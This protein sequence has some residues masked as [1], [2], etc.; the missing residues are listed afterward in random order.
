MRAARKIKKIIILALIP[1]ILLGTLLSVIPVQS[2]PV[3]AGGLG[4]NPFKDDFDYTISGGKLSIIDTNNLVIYKS[5][6]NTSQSSSPNYFDCAISNSNCLSSRTTPAQIIVSSSGSCGVGEITVYETSAIRAASAYTPST[7]TIHIYNTSLLT[8]NNNKLTAGLTCSTANTTGPVVSQGSSWIPPTNPNLSQC[9]NNSNSAGCSGSTRASCSQNSNNPTCQTAQCEEAN[10]VLDWAFCAIY[11]GM[12]SISNW[13]LN[14]VIQPLLE[15]T[16][17]C[18]NSQGTGCATSALLR[19]QQQGSTILNPTYAIWSSFRLYGDIVLVIAL[20]VAVISEAA[21]GG[22]LDTYT[23]RKMLPRILVAGILLNLSIYIVAA[24]VDVFNILGGT[25]GSIITAPIKNAGLFTITPTKGAGIASWAGVGVGIIVGGAHLHSLFSHPGG[26]MLIDGVLVPILLILLAIVITIIL[27]TAAITALVIISPIAFALYCLPNTQKYFKRWWDL[28]LEMLLMYPIITLI[29]AV[30]SVMSVIFG[31]QA[32]LEGTGL[33]IVTDLLALAFTFLPLLMI[34]FS[35]KLAGETIGRVAGAVD[36]IRSKAMQMHAPR[37][38]RAKEAYKIR[39]AGEKAKMYSSGIMSDRA[40]GRGL[41]RIP[42]INRAYRGAAARASQNARLMG[43]QVTQLPGW[44]AIEHDDYALAALTNF[45]NE[46]ATAQEISELTG[47]DMSRSTQAAREAI[48]RART[49]VDFGGAQAIMA[50]RQRAVTGTGYANAEQME[51]TIARVARGDETTRASLAGDINSVSKQVGR[52]DLGPGYSQVKEMADLYDKQAKGLGSS[53]HKDGMTVDEAIVSGMTKNAIGGWKSGHLGD[54][55]NDKPADIENAA[56]A[57][58]KIYTNPNSSAEEVD[59][60]IAFFQ[61][62]NSLKSY[63][64]IKGESLDK[65]NEALTSPEGQRA[66]TAYHEM[67]SDAAT[68]SLVGHPESR[69][70]I[71]RINQS[72]RRL[73]ARPQTD[74]TGMP[75][76]GPSGTNGETTPPGGA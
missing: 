26:S 31:F 45:G 70:R 59:S 9:S 30:S 23:V 22:L 68:G 35:F 50:A 40:L 2:A 69:E 24:L 17:I 55:A 7:S 66:L 36:G 43:N 29:F 39:H 58:S 6:G 27:R 52:H 46:R 47:W 53:V 14:K 12:N 62:L 25:I 42:G 48:T 72:V 54:H 4:A 51:K 57:F 73:D 37:R 10:G 63:G 32:Q 19:N 5:G 3:A 34:P 28:L 38:E 76:P 60:A 18:T 11:Q 49:A 8:T 33:G 74:S 41:S 61:E 44:K 16:P 67:L 64:Y 1:A 20:L 65:V 13:L 71:E 56:K 21:G 15:T 75:M